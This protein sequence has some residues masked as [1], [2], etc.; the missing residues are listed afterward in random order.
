MNN[1]YPIEEL[2]LHPNYLSASEILHSIL[3]SEIP[4]KKDLNNVF[5]ILA[6]HIAYNLEKHFATFPVKTEK[7]RKHTAGPSVIAEA[8]DRLAMNKEY[9]T[10]HSKI[11]ANEIP[12]IDDIYPVYGEYSD[13]V[14]NITALYKTY[15][16]KRKCE[17]PAVAHPSRV[18]GLVNT[19]GFDSP[20]SHKFCTIAFLH[21]C[22]EDLVR[23]EKRSHFDH[24]GLKGLGMFINDFIPEELQPNVRLLTNHYSLILNYLNYLL[25]ISDI[26]LNKK[27][28]LKNL[29]GLSSM[30]W[31]LNEKVNKLHAL[32]DEN[33]LT[34][35]VLVNAKWLCYRDLYIREMADDAL[36]MSD[37]R[38]FEIKAIDLTDNAQGS[39]ALSM[40]ER[41][42][43]IV[44]LCIW[45][46]QGYRLHTSWSPTNNFIEELFEYAL[47]YSEH[48]VIKDFLQPDL[49]QDLF[50]SALF[51]IEELKSVFFT[52]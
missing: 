39:G 7:I 3:R 46:N 10:L 42:R 20:G 32:L 13:N 41:L 4:D 19:L 23:F 45:A 34:E 21:D 15:R 2:K 51:K 38:T 37:F 26:Q 30:D 50:A 22:I 17:I 6:P 25:T 5:G 40:T 31:S 12:S 8:R 36:A 47:N 48:I 44:K 9:L 1:L 52:A 14:Q 11:L 35:P 49:K 18:G 33:D 27:N 43:N 24:Y 16:L 29:E 28:L